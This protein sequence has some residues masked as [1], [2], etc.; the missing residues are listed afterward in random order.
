MNILSILGKTLTDNSIIGAI[1]S[2]IAIIFLGFY[3]RKKD[4]IKKQKYI[5]QKK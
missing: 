4:I 5:L 2:S 3:L 1:F